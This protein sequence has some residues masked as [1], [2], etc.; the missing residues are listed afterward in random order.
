MAVSV[1]YVL[2]RRVPC[3][4]VVRFRRSGSKD[5]EIVVLRHELAILR[6]QVSRPQLTDADR[7]FLAAASR[8]LGRRRWS[9]FVVRPETLLRWHRRL[10]ARHWTYAH[11]S[12]GRPPIDPY[13]RALI[14]RLARENPR[15]GYLGIQGE[16]AGLGISVSATT[17][18]R[19]LQRAGLDPSGGRHSMSWRDFVRAQARTISATDFFTVDTMFLKRLYVLFFIEIDTRR[20]HLAG[21]TGHPTG[22]WVTQQASD[23]RVPPG[24]VTRMGFGTQ[25]AARNW[26]K[27]RLKPRATFF[28]IRSAYA[29][30]PSYFVVHSDRWR[31]STGATE[32][33]TCESATGSRSPGRTR[34]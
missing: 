9:V 33:S 5:L 2:V 22:P 20:V 23:S 4:L 1:L 24:C 16:L 7:V 12:P 15:W 30:D 11:Q 31:W 18:R 10:V 6:R 34:P 26:K 3:L 8:L 25:Q 29:D 28:G 21:V 14:L 13:V 17:I 32:P 19:V 27:P